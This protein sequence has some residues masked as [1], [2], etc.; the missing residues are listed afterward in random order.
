MEIFLRGRSVS[1]SLGDLPCVKGD[2]YVLMED[3]VLPQ[4]QELQDLKRDDLK[5]FEAL[6]VHDMHGLMAGKKLTCGF[7]T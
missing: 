7:F 3:L 6:V 1:R 4:L 2:L 5:V